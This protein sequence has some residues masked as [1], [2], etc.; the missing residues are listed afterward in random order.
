MVVEGS[1]EE[2]NSTESQPSQTRGMKMQQGQVSQ[3]TQLKSYSW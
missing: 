2:E 1:L 3:R